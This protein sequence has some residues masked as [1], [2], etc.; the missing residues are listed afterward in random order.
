MSTDSTELTFVRCPSCRSLVPAVST[1]CRMCGA[2]LEASDKVEPKSEDIATRTSR[3][4]QRTMTEQ[5]SELNAAADKLRDENSTVLADTSPA[6]ELEDEDPLAD[7][8]ADT[9]IDEANMETKSP[10][11]SKP[12]DEEVAPLVASNGS[13]N[14]HHLAE[15]AKESKVVVESGG[16]PFDKPSGLSFG[17]REEKK[18]ISGDK[19]AAAAVE[20]RAQQPAAQSKPQQGVEKQHSQSTQNNQQ[21]QQQRQGRDQSAQGRDGNREQRAQASQG[22]QPREDRRSGQE[23]SQERHREDRRNWHEPR[24]NR[25]GAASKGRSD[26]QEQRGSKGAQVH[27]ASVGG[28]LVGWLVT[29]QDPNGRSLELRESKF[30]VTRSSLK[31]SDLVIDDPSVSTPHAMLKVDPAGS[32]KVQDLMS[33]RGVYVKRK[34]GNSFQKE[35]ELCVL[36]HGDWIRFGDVEYLVCLIANL[37]T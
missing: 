36:S 12:K 30:F 1:R 21:S 23:R 31:P 3:V 26:N 28:M 25:E 2:T 15:E 16:K 9:E 37:G 5:D 4:K 17:K 35:E 33:D 32:I 6:T 27:K 19:S 22:N 8:L 24:D 14:G 29:Y 13:S 10:V 7:F 34:N 20:P 11:A 18:E